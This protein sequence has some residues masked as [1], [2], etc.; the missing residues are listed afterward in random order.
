MAQAYSN[1]GEKL[2]VYEVLIEKPYVKG[3]MRELRTSWR[4]I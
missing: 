2:G 4:I 1:H 3:E